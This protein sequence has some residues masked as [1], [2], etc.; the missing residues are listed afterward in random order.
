MIK[1]LMVGLSVCE[2]KLVYGFPFL[3]LPMGCQ[4]LFTLISFV[5]VF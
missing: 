2:I 4:S 1:G 3:K 5:I